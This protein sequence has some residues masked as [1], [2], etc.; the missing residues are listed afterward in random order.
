MKFGMVP[1]YGI[2]WV[3]IGGHRS[4]VKVTRLKNVIQWGFSAFR[5]VKGHLGQ[6]QISHGSRSKVM[7]IKGHSGQGQR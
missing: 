4:K 3:D 5:K 6:G 7:E 1:Y 2:S